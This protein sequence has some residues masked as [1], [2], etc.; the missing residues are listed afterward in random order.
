VRSIFI[1]VF[2]GITRCDEIA[3]GIVDFAPQIPISVRMMGTHEEEGKKI[4]IENG[5]SVSDTIE[6]SAKQAIKLAEEG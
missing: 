6:K 1:N 4:L 5:Y 2:G 3:K